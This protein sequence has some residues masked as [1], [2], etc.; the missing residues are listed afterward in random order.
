MSEQFLN[1]S[2]VVTVREEMGCKTVTKAVASD[3][4]MDIRKGYRLFKGFS[5][6]AFM[7][8]MASDFSRPWIFA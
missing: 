4:F 8:V 7:Q 2:D 5:N 6:T 3:W 1:R